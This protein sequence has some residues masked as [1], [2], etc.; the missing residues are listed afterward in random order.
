MNRTYLIAGL[1]GV[2]G[3]AVL[4]IAAWWSQD[5]FREAYGNGPPYYG[6]T[7]NM[8]KWDSPIAVLV[9][10]DVLALGS[11]VGLVT[12]ALRRFRVS[13]LLRQTDGG[14]MDKPS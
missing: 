9:I 10:V 4:L 2:L 8:D 1:A 3:V 5:V 13:K 12:Y 6:R 11:G 7:T 14:E